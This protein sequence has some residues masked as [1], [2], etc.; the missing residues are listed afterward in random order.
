MPNVKTISIFDLDVLN[1]GKETAIDALLAPGSRNTAAFVNAHCFNVAARDFSYRWALQKADFLLPD[2][3]GVRVAARLRSEAFVEN[4]NGTDLFEP[5]CRASAKRCMPVYFLGSVAGVAQLAAE[6]ACNL[7]PGLSVAGSRHGYFSEEENEEV[8]ADINASGAQVILVALGVPKQDV[9]IA[10]NRHRLH[11]HLVLGVGAQFDFWSGRTPRAP[12]LVRKAGLEWMARLA[13]EP[14]RLAR[15][16]LIGNFEFVARAAARQDMRYSSAPAY[17]AVKRFMDI[18]LASVGIFALSPLIALI[19]AAVRL[20]SA[21]PAFFTQIR[22]GKNGEAFTIYKFRSMYRDAEARR[23]K[24]LETSDRT[25]ICFK[26]RNDPRVTRVG[27]FLRRFSLDELPQIFNVWKGEM[28]IVGLR[29]ALP[30]EVAKY[31]VRA[32]RRF[33]AKPGMTG[34]WQVSGRAEVDF[35]KMIEIDTAYVRSRSI[36]LDFMLIGLTFRAV[37]SGRGAY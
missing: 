11:A 1:E 2:G 21:G 24:L 27:K 33:E 12:L 23:A 14:R 30:Q 35:E 13:L 5:L 15:R 26:S 8:I 36:L 31:P 25:G 18:A 17:G 22:V 29:P 16:Y 19:G 4:L 3:A 6:A 34:L 9:W 28:S 10:R 37:L 32:L 7:A 20:E